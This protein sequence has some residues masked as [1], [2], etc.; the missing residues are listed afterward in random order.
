VTLHYFLPFKKKPIKVS[1]FFGLGITLIF[2]IALIFIFKKI[3]SPSPPNPSNKTKMTSRVCQQEN[4]NKPLSPPSR[5]SK[6]SFK[7]DF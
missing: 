5:E 4:A 7:N 6:K 2:E 1:N 3:Q